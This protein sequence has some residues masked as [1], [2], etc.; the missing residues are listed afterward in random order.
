MRILIF[1]LLLLTIFSCVPSAK[2]SRYTNASQNTLDSI[3]S[4][5]SETHYSANA[6]KLD[7]MF[8]EYHSSLKNLFDTTQISNWQAKIQSIKVGEIVVNN[9]LY[10]RV[11]FKLIN[12]LDIRPKITFEAVY[13]VQPDSIKKDN[14]Y[15]KIK[16]LGNLDNVTFSGKI[17]PKDDGSLLTVYDSLGKDYL[18]TF[19]TFNFILTDINKS[20]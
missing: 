3:V 15:A 2:Y 14:V 4:Y 13:Y 8:T 10:K 11:S 1:S 17:L 7:E 19:P 20:L 12:G 16:N 6:L 5:Y 9:V 18:F